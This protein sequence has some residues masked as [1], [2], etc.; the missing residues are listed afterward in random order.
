MSQYNEYIGIVN[1]ELGITNKEDAIEDLLSIVEETDDQK[2]ALNKKKKR[3]YVLNRFHRNYAKVKS[4]EISMKGELAKKLG[5]DAD[6]Q[7]IENAMKVY[8]N[9][10]RENL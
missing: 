7:G 1:S 9:Y 4:E 2:D 10:R 5:Y 8:D 3:E 6:P